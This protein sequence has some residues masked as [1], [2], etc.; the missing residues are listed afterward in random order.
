MLSTSKH[1]FSLL[2]FSG[3]L[4]ISFSTFAQSKKSPCNESVAYCEGQVTFDNGNI[5]NGEFVY[6]VP[7]GKGLMKFQGGS[8]Y[9]G[10]FKN[11]KMEGQGTIL[12][13]SGDSYLGDWKDGEADG[14]GTYKK[15][16]GSSFKG[17]FKNGMRQGKG[18]VT[19]KTG[20]TL[21]GEWQEDKLNGKAIFEFA[22]GDILDTKWQAGNM[23]VKST[24]TKESGQKIQGSMNTIYMVVDMENDFAETKETMVANLQLAWMSAAMEFKANQNYDLAVDFLMAAQKYGPMNPESQ[25]VI[26]QQMKAIDTQKNN[27]GWAQLPKK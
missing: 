9:L 10:D 23:K 2:L 12:L 7:S 3:I 5:Y 27:S 14:N 8:E 18:I 11:G 16:D 20:D 19:W 15:N 24:Y 26:A 21:R 22:N 6:G 13:A 1:I 4:F 25:A 17:T